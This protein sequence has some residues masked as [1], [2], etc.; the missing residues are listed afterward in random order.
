MDFW[1]QGTHGAMKRR[2]QSNIANKLSIQFSYA[3]NIATPSFYDLL[4]SLLLHLLAPEFSSCAKESSPRL[5]ELVARIDSLSHL[6]T[7]CN[8]ICCHCSFDND[9]VKCKYRRIESFGFV[10]LGELRK[11]LDKTPFNDKER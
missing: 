7:P 9:E 8:Q 11:D 10:P 2:L 3:E 4:T 1:S 5:S 6:S